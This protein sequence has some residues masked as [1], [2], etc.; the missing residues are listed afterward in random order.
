MERNAV[1]ATVLVILILFGYQWYLSH[2]EV[3]PQETQRPAPSVG[4]SKDQP[5]PAPVP[6]ASVNAPSLPVPAQ[7]STQPRGYTPTAE[8]GLAVKDVTVETP[9]MR[10]T[11]SP[12]GAGVI[13]WQLKKYQLEGGSPVELVA[14]QDPGAGL[15]PLETW[16]DDRRLPGI[17]QVD[18]DRLSL[19]GEESG[20]LTF[21]QVDA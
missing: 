9:L 19:G 21:T 4:T 12:L 5:A 13:H 1:L 7:A 2:Y 17:F 8:L 15:G 6:P 11:L 16:T 18:R 10:V 20:T 3:P 14:V